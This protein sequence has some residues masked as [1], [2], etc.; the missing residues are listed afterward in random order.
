MVMQKKPAVKKTVRARKKTKTSY[1]GN[2]N[3]KPFGYVHEFT[4]DQIH[5]IMK[6][7]NDVIYFVE[8][9]VKIISLDHGQVDFILYDF[10][11]EKIRRMLDERMLIIIEPRQQGKTVT[12]AAA[13]LWYTLFNTEKTVAI[14]AHKGAGARQV[15]AIYQLMYENLPI[16]LQQ[17][18]KTWN[19]GDIELENGT[20]IFTSATT[21][22]GIRGRSVNWLY[23]DEAAIIPNNV[24]EEFFASTYPVISA[25]K[26]TKILLT[27]TPLGYNHFWKFWNEAQHEADCTC[28][29]GA[30]RTKLGRNGFNT[31][32][33]PY[34]RHP[35]RNEAWVQEQYKRLGE[36]KFNQ[37][38]LCQFLGSALT[39]INGAALSRLSIDAPL[40]EKNS[41]A[42]YTEPIKNHVYVTTVDTSEGIGGDACAFIV[43]DVTEMPYRVVARYKDHFIRPMLFPS[44]IF[45]TARKF[46]DSWVLIETD[47]AGRTVADILHDDLEYENVLYTNS[48]NGK[49]VISAGFGNVSNIGL[50]QNKTTKRVG[51]M[52]IKTLVEEQQFLFSDADI[53]SEM[54]TFI[55]KGQSYKA[56][57]GYFDDLMMCCVMMGWIIT[58]P[59]FRELTNIDV[60]KKIFRDNELAIEAEI[61]PPMP[62]VTTGDDSDLIVIDDQGDIWMS[63]ELDPET[64][65]E[66][67]MYRDLFSFVK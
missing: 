31:M 53:I 32:F 1:H 9:Y 27:S 28:S 4:P 38:V 26:T 46:N 7:R 6:C 29:N 11:K 3:L 60:R 37:E 33:I 15:M 62:V 10:Q 45:Q 2:K 35:E 57:E 61:M 67:S 54:T 17:G 22:S 23:I 40:Y 65:S 66:I 56:D 39:L 5:E 63:A 58:N 14:L 30:C 13:I 42:V 49:T 52:G 48:E 19:K 55:Q 47:G 8:K 25:G 51:C 64:I 12:A 16:W 20:S 43:V 50:K 34:T 18:V 59:Y 21:A 41:L 44:I 24:A 36:T